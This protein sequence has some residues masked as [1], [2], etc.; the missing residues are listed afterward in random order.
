MPRVKDVEA[1]VGE[2]QPFSACAM[3][4]AHGTQAGTIAWL[5]DHRFP[6]IS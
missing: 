1:S 6:T 5:E 3:L 2:D 4:L